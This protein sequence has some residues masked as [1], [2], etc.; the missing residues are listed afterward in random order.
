M[1]LT[2]PITQVSFDFEGSQAKL[3]E[4]NLSNYPGEDISALCS[5]DQKQIKVMQS[6]Y[7]LPI[8]VGSK[9]L[10][11]CTKTECEYFNRKVFDHLEKLR[12]CKTST[13]FQ[14]L[15]H[16]P[17]IQDAMNMAQSES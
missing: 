8:R 13:S 3:D 4:L 6:G 7:A 11:K 16:L 17:M 1:S 9:Q 10:M 2:Y 15:H 12:T 5:D 14:I